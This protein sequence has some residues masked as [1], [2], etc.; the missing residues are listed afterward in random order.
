MLAFRYLQFLFV[1]HFAVV[2]AAEESAPLSAVDGEGLKNGQQEAAIERLSSGHAEVLSAFE[3]PGFC[4]GELPKNV[5]VQYRILW[6]RAFHPPVFVSIVE[7][8]DGGVYSTLVEIDRQPRQGAAAKKTS[9]WTDVCQSGSERLEENPAE[10][11]EIFKMGLEALSRHGFWSQDFEQ[12]MGFV[13]DGSTWIVEGR[14]NDQCHVASR[15]S[16]KPESEFFQFVWQVLS[17]TGKRFYF[18]E[19]Y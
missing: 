11:C 14:K 7:H 5:V 18:D 2:L 13:F 6:V 8:S 17:T 3:E 1:L 4:A 12:D 19:V 15:Q 16:P 10:F 9:T